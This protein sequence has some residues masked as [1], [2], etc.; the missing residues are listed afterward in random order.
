M[1]RFLFIISAR[2][3]M[4][5]MFQ[6]DK[7][8]VIQGIDVRFFVRKIHETVIGKIVSIEKNFN[9]LFII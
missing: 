6:E 4:P 7:S 5:D 3:E 9:G 2:E 1:L 8:R